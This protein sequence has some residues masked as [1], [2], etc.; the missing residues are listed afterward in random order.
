MRVFFIKKIREEKKFDNIETLKIAIKKDCKIA[1]K[2]FRGL[3]IAKYILKYKVIFAQILLTLLVGLFYSIK[4]PDII[5]GFSAVIGSSIVLV[6]TILFLWGVFIARNM[7]EARQGIIIAY[8]FAGVRFVL[9]AVLLIVGILSGL[10]VLPM[11]V[12]FVVAQL[13]QFVNLFKFK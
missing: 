11:I 3:F 7:A 9:V 13:G 10:K 8:L 2:H 6:N 1:Q 4:N 12:G 5:M